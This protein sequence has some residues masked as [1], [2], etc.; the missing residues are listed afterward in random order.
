[1]KS[2]VFLLAVV[3]LGLVACDDTTEDIGASVLPEIDKVETTNATYQVISRYLMADSVLANTS[4]AYLVA[5]IDP[6]THAMTQ[7]SYMAQF[8]IQEDF[9]FPDKQLM[10]CDENGRPIIDSCEIR[11]FMSQYYGDSL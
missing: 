6:E 7:C 5:I 8:N 2:K 11:I 1:M 3:L 4:N 9:R 10:N